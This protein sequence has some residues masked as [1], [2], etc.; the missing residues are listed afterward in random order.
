M[1]CLIVLAI[2]NGDEVENIDEFFD[3]IEEMDDIIKLMK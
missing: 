1:K 3:E 2:P